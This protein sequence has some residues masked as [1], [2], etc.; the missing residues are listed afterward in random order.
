M[1]AWVIKV[2][3]SAASLLAL[4]GCSENFPGFDFP[5]PGTYEHRLKIRVYGFSR[6]YL[7]HIP[8]GYDPSTALPLVVALHGG[9]GTARQMEEES[10]L[11]EL[12]DREGYLVLYPNGITLLGWLQHW[13]A[14]HCCGQAMKDGIDDVGFVS[15]VIDQTCQ[16]LKVDLSR[17][18]M[19]GYSNGGMLAHFF[20]AQRPE[21]IAA[22]ATIAATIGSRPSPSEAEV[23]IPP[24]KAPVPIIAFHG[25][26]DDVVPYER[27]RFREWRHLYVPVK[28]S[29]AFWITAN[30]CAFVPQRQEMM[31][32]RVLKETWTGKN[33]RG[34]AVLYT[35]EGWKH[36]LPTQ[37]HTR[38]LAETDPLTGFHATE[39]IWEFFKG[40]R[41]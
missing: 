35:L 3:L 13:N 4:W 34:K 17:I 24:A 23:R 12:A 11:S 9:F 41:R 1:G 36:S 6:S 26:E 40:H 38:K 32:G 15:M 31:S 37:H 28:E 18:Y 16:R 19:V 10:G 27:G 8:K 7:L 39:H 21:T 29:M 5:H 20:A 2:L 14:G 25:R 22:V 30:Q 33:K